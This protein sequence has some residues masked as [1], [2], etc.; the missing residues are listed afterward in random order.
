M[1][2]KL[3]QGKA[4]NKSYKNDMRY[5]RVVDLV[6]SMKPARP[7]YIYDLERMRYQAKRFCSAFAGKPLY[8]VKTNTDENAIRAL[9]SG[10]IKAFDVAS[11]DE[12]RRVKAVMPNAELHFMHPI[13][14]PEDIR[15]AYF[16]YGVRHFVLDHED[17]LFK[18]IRETE[19]AQDLSLTVRISLPKNDDA[20][21]DFSAKFGAAFDDALMLLEKCRPVSKTL[22]LSFHVGTQTVTP[23]KYDLAIGYCARLIDASGVQVDSLN[24]GGGFP[25][26]YTGDDGLDT[27]ETYMDHINA[28]LA[29]NGLSELKLL[30]EPGRVLVA[31]S[32]KLVARVELRKGDVLYINDGVY[33]GLFDAARWVGTEFPVS[34]VSCDRPFDG[35][36]A[37]F[38]LAGPTCDGL[39]MMDGPFELPADIGMGDW[40]I[41]ENTGAYSQVLRSDFNGFG[42]YD[43]AVL[44]D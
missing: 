21:I 40:I 26:A 43:V 28:A 39:D 27:I 33:G 2:T 24:I 4:L 30:A 18:I 13:K 14:T 22:G 23:A 37:G 44:R 3:I 16:E 32:V 34:A 31:E 41:F 25:V 29:K 11:L 20:L 19:L 1:N 12:I 6:S 9:I 8:A 15:A 42:A 35:S 17:E 5:A 36:K 38:R 7:L 10:G